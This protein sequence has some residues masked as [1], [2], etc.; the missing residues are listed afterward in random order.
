MR[1][2]SLSVLLCLLAVVGL[3][4]SMGCNAFTPERTQRRVSVARQDLGRIPD[5]VDWVLG[6]D[7]P[8]IIYDDS[9]PPYKY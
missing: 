4:V 6:F 9:F 1:K 2:R 5:E 3:V 8:S 7:E